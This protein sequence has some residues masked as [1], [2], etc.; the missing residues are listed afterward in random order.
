MT[1]L[2]TTIPPYIVHQWKEKG[3]REREGA[4]VLFPTEWALST[5]NNNST[6]STSG[7]NPLEKIPTSSFPGWVHR[8]RDAEDSRVASSQMRYPRGVPWRAKWRA[9]GGETNLREPEDSNLPLCFMKMEWAVRDEKKKE[10]TERTKV[11]CLRGVKR[12]RGSEGCTSQVP[13]GL[14][15]IARGTRV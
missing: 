2:F 5:T 8:F 3:G 6:F 14:V 13:G 10:L 7:A 15:V 1:L 9:K 4:V 11:K 12:T